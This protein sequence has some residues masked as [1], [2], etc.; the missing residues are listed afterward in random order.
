MPESINNLE[1]RIV[2]LEEQVGALQGK[3]SAVEG[4]LG[5][6]PGKG[7]ASHERPG[8]KESSFLARISSDEVLSWLDTSAIMPRVATT[9]FILVLAIALRTLTDN[10]TVDQQIGAALGMLYGFILLVVGWSGYGR[11][12]IQAPVFTLWGTFVLCS[13]V[14]ETYRVFNVL[15]TELA[16]ISLVLLGAATAAISRQYQVVLPVFAGTLGMSFGGFAIDYP[17]PVFPYLIVLLIIANML[18]VYA[19]RLLRASW[20]RWLLLALTVFMFQIWALKLTLFLNRAEPGNI[21]FAISGFFPGI[22]LIGLMYLGIAFFGVVGKIQARVSKFDISLP[23]VN[24]IWISILCRYVINNGLADPTVFGL[25]ASV[26]AGG[27]L[28]LA[29]FLGKQDGPASAGAAP[30]GLAG[31]LLLALTLPMGIGNALISSTIMAAI[32]FGGA[33][34]A[35]QWKSGGVRYV[36]YFM[37]IYAAGTLIAALSAAEMGK[38]SI[39]GATASTMMAAIGLWHYY[40]CRENPPLPEM[41][42]FKN[43]DKKDRGASFILIAA[44]FSCFFT[45][46]VGIFQ[47][48]ALVGVRSSEAFSSGQSVVIIFSS[49][50]MMFLSGRKKNRELRTI[51]ILLLLAG[52]CKVFLLDIMSMKGLPLIT[53]LFSFGLA[54]VFMQLMNRQWNREKKKHR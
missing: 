47:G 28:G 37:Q 21:E 50:L 10:G 35:Q 36:S 18:T 41:R 6:L 15:P 27:H 19:S 31:C 2:E 1:Q 30:L 49:A 42:V 22:A 33:L 45:V 14:V 46:R 24:V 32:A 8:G 38:P 20:I 44:L 4:R 39:V 26:F 40:W 25:T 34:L 23:V 12:S 51:G 16:Y 53:A 7:Q 52:A 3:L 9:S 5:N 43:F 13:V 17:S 11:K 48:L 29:W 54:V